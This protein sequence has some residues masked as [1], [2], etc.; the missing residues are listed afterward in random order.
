MGDGDSIGDG[1]FVIGDGTTLETAMATSSGPPAMIVTTLPEGFTAGTFGGYKVLGKLEDFEQPATNTCANVLRLIVRDF[2]QAHV[3]FGQEKP[4]TWTA[5]GLEG[6]YPGQVLAELPPD[7]RKP[8]INPARMPADVIENLSDWYVTTEGVNIPYV[9]DIWLA[10]HATKPDTFEFEVNDFFPLDDWNETPA[11]VQNGRNFLFTTELHTKFEYKG[12]EVFTFL[13]DDDVFAFVNHQLGVDLGGI[14][15]PK[16]GS[17]S[18]D[19]QATAF[20]LTVGETYDLD[21]FQAERNPGGSN[22]RIET[23]LDFKECG[24]LPTDVIV[25]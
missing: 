23:S 13:G 21:L 3:D 22:Y 18:L 24:L 5:D 14:H 1:D 16:M 7:T 15:G 20:G 8:L 19:A 11:D 9:M 25:K 10:P 12:G 6:L 17:V 2:T 4:A